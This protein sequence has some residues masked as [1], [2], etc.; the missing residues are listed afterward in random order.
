MPPA[1]SL[2]LLAA[3]GATCV[4]GVITAW[5]LGR[6]DLPDGFQNEFIHLF[7]LTE[8]WFRGRDEGI[9]AAWP[10][11]WDE[12]YPPGIQAVAAGALAILGPGRLVAT[13]SLGLFGFILFHAVG[14][15]TRE[16][17]GPRTAAVAILWIAVFPAI[18]GNL[19]RFE[20][21]IAVSALAAAAVASLVQSR[22]LA[23]WKAGVRFGAWVGLGLLVDRLSVGLYLLGPVLVVLLHELRRGPKSRVLLRWSV[24][25]AVAA[26][27]CGY[28]Y[29]RFFRLHWE[30]VWTQ[31]AHEITARGEDVQPFTALSWR[32][33]LYYPLSFFDHQMGPVVAV[34]TAGGLVGWVRA[35]RAVEPLLRAVIESWFLVSLLLLTAIGKKQPYYTIPIL[36]P[37]AILAVLGWAAL[38]P[39]SRWRLA[40][41]LVGGFFGLHQLAFL[42]TGHGLIP[43]PGRW[44]WFA[45]QPPLPKDFLGETYVQAAA[46]FEQGLDLPRIV[47][48]CRRAE[49]EGTR[50]SVLL[51]SEGQAAYEGQLMPTLRLAMD[52][53]DVEGLVM[54]P[55]AV[56]GHWPDAACF[57]FVDRAGA[58]WP[59]A[60]TMKTTLAGFDQSPPS[61]ALIALFEAARQRAIVVDRWPTR[62]GEFVTVFALP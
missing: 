37:A 19:R 57:V 55:P 50:H 14:R 22:G 47:A 62:M 3:A 43:T 12:Y 28:Y 48:G 49:G 20:P 56:L 2:P 32:N 33:L 10:F 53:R 16:L 9:A 25:G 26:M 42:S 61:E 60:S 29:Q 5:W 46:P 4:L 41:G 27:I 31:R 38:L 17:A 15:I 35:R 21:N 11:L 59:E 1:R 51:Y 6:N 8:A 39:Q 40:A 36:A 34:L 23:D 58:P 54:G 44:A 18:F 30:E 13:L 45:G 24:A 7:T 52:R